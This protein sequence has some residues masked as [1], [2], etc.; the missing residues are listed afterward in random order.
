M[1]TQKH[2]EGDLIDFKV[3][4]EKQVVDAIYKMARNTSY[5][6]DELVVIA[7][8]KFIASHSDYMGNAPR[9]E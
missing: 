7:L 2:N 6:T 5:T 1:K 9:Y 3:K 8:K 4:I